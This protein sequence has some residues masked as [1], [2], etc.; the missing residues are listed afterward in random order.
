[1]AYD[2]NLDDIFQMAVRIEENGAE[3]YRK[4][5]QTRT[6]SSERVFLENLA[7]MEDQHKHQFLRLYAQLPDHVKTPTAFDPKEENTAYLMAMADAHDGEGNPDAAEAFT[8]TETIKEIVATAMELEKKSILFYIGLQELVPE[9]Y[10]GDQIQA[11]IKEE[12][13]HVAQ[14]QAVLV[15]PNI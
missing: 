7:R 13:Q 9:K 2:F 5:A 8:G 10:G 11:I 14:L 1:M 3:F 12:Q 4:A 15:R 6:E